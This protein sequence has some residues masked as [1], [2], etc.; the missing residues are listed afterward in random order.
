MGSIKKMKKNS[1]IVH[2]HTTFFMLL[3]SLAL[4]AIT[5]MFFFHYERVTGDATLY[6]S[7]AEKYI[8]GDFS[9]AINGYWGP[10]LSWL[11]IPFLF[12][13]S[14]HVFAI[15]ALNLVFGL[16]TIIGVWRLTYRFEI[17][18][19]IRS[20][21][22]FP[23]V[24]ILLFVSLIEPMD[25]LL[26]SVLVYY[27]SIVFSKDYPEKVRN[28]VVGGL[29]GACAYFSKPY[30][31][32]FF[33]AHFFMIN[34]CHYFRSTSKE[35]KKNVLRNALVGF[36]IFSLLSGVWIALISSKYN[37]LTFSNMGRGVFASLGPESEHDTL[38]KGDP[39]LFKGFF[40]PPN[41]TAFIIYEDP[42]YARRN[43]WSP[44]ESKSSFQ[45][46]LSNFTKNIINGLRIYESY[47]RLSIAIIIAYILLIFALPLNKQ[48]SRGDLL[49]PLLT[50]ILYTGG[51]IPFH[52]EARY[53]WIVNILLFLM[54]GKVLNELFQNEFFKNK[55]IQ[56]I[57]I[58]FFILSFI[59]TPLK[60]SAG[61]SRNNINRD[62]YTLGTELNKRY[63]LQGNIASNRQKVRLSPHDSWHQTFRLAYWLQGR[64]FGQA[65]ENISDIDLENEL[66]T[67]DIDYYFLWGESALIPRFLSQ[68]RELTGG[69]IEDLRIFSL[70]E[71][72]EM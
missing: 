44:L 55:R 14:T 25:F 23:L 62:M 12:F 42:S 8:R 11:L 37:R 60:S 29:L 70:K 22:L 56:N 6:L 40:E 32:S 53:L 66:K 51:Y 65:R 27:L 71:K 28:G 26:L 58:I 17:H 2:D 16:L 7:I 30:G 21:I 18:E 41:E 52:F 48:L 3:I 67:F 39:I 35:H 34:V 43:T 68:Y 1:H 10:L 15:N 33:I 9:N 64:Y 45:H 72:R 31:F 61:M 69:D 4:Y 49:Y 20:I 36:L 5:C 19:K 24:P 46:F 54:G 38:E 47:S 59:I 63:D 13:G 57:L 50:V